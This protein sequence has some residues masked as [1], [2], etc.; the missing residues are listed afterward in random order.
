[1]DELKAAGVPESATNSELKRLKCP[2][3]DPNTFF[4]DQKQFDKARKVYIARCP[5]A[6]VPEATGRVVARERGRL[7]TNLPKAQNEQIR[8][9]WTNTVA[10][11]AHQHKVARSTLALALREMGSP[12]YLFPP[13]GYWQMRASGQTIALPHEVQ[14]VFPKGL[15]W[16]SKP[17]GRQVVLKRPGLVWFFHLEKESRRYC[18]A[19]R[20]V[21]EHGRTGNPPPAPAPTSA[22]PLAVETRT[23]QDS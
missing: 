21:A 17:V 4:M 7:T 6:A 22:D 19:A 5:E 10:D 2:V 23:S 3:D 16:P 12:Q 1:M 8:L 15:P 13:K 9:V 14:N 11:L 18:A 20:L